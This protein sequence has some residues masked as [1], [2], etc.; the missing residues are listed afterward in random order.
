MPYG[1]TSPQVTGPGNIL[2]PDR[3]ANHL[4][5]TA[6]QVQTMHLSSDT[7]GDRAHSPAGELWRHIRRAARDVESFSMAV[8]AA[9]WQAPVP[10]DDMHLLKAIPLNSAPEPKIPAASD[11][12]PA[13]CAGTG[14]AAQRVRHALRGGAERAWWALA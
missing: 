5:T 13:L 2:A 9:Q 12:V 7:V 14:G 11:A 3:L 4:S 1:H 6:R 8:Q 10:D